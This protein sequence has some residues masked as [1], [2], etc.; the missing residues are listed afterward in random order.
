MA[1]GRRF[2]QN[3]EPAEGWVPAQAVDDPIL[4]SPYE[5]PAEHWTYLKGVPCRSLHSPEAQREGLSDVS[6]QEL[7]P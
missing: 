4:S 7:R 2:I 1:R 3:E 6:T 5:E